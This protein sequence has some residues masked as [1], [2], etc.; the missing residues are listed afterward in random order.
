MPRPLTA[1]NTHHIAS[2]LCRIGLDARAAIE[3]HLGVHRITYGQHAILVVVAEQPGVYVRELARR[4]HLSRQA[5]LTAARS[6]ARRQLITIERQPPD[7]RLAR[8]HL[9]P[10]GEAL[11]ATLAAKLAFL[12]NTIARVAHP[13]AP[14]RLAELLTR[15]G[16]AT[17]FDPARERPGDR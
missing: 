2:L 16:D 4:V 14:D 17:G 15:I 9:T 5:V 10:A 7:P 1:A 8:L 13:V 11:V 6:L 12:E 3:R